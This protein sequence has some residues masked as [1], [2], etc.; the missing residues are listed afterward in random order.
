MNIK[1]I[2]NCRDED[3]KSGITD[4]DK[5]RVLHDNI[6]ADLRFNNKLHAKLM[7]IDSKVAIISSANLTRSGLHVNYEAGV[8]I[9]KK[10][11]V[12]K[13]AEF[14]NDVWMRSKPLTIDMVK[15]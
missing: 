9:K 4:K 8:I 10:R 6:G 13:A 2:T 1:V 11:D 7:I 12:L 3:I 5:L 15:G 14:F